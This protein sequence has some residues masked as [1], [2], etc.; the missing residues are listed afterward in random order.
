[1]TVE[2]VRLGGDVAPSVRSRRTTV[3]LPATG[4]PCLVFVFPPSA[5]DTKRAA[6][7]GVE[8]AARS[9][10]PTMSGF[11]KVSTGV[12]VLFSTMRQ[13]TGLRPGSAPSAV[14]ARLPTTTHPP[15]RTAS[16]VVSP[17]PPGQV[18]PAGNCE[19]CANT[20]VEPPGETCTMVLPV[21]WAFPLSLKLL[22]SVS[23]AVN[24]PMEGGTTA[25][26]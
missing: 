13:P 23:P 4:T 17:I 15:G 12:P 25:T 11:V 18:W 7:V 21:P 3:H 22:T 8:A 10:G 5:L 20:W 2:L 19:I 24:R 1:M 16:A 9:H 14:L 26:P 6:V